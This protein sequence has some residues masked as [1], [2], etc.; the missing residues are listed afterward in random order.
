MDDCISKLPDKILSYILTMLSMKDL[1]KTSILSRRWCKLWGLRK[2]LYFDINNV[3]GSEEELIK[4]G[5]LID[6]NSRYVDLKVSRD[7]FVKRVDQFLKNF[8]G[9]KID[10]FLLSFNLNFE[11]SSIIDQ[12]ISF[13]IAKGVEKINLLFLRKPFIPLD[14]RYKFSFD[15]FSKTDASNL[16][17]LHLENCHLCHP[18]NCDFE[19][20]KNLRSLSLLSVKVDEIFIENLLSNCQLLEELSLVD[21]EFKSSTPKIISSSLCHLNVS[22]CCKV[23][24]NN[25][26]TFIELMLVDCLK[27]TSLECSRNDLS[28][29]NTNQTGS[30]NINSHVL[31]RI[32]FC[33][34]EYF[35]AFALCETFPELEVMHLE[36]YPMVMPLLIIA[37]PFKHLTQLD[38]FIYFS[39]TI[40]EEC[41]L[42]LILNFFQAS[43]LLQKLSVMIT[44]PVLFEIDKNIRDIGVFSHNEVKVIELGGCVGNWYEIEFVMNVLK[45]AP[46]LEQIVLSPYWREDDSS[47]WNSNPVWFQSGRV[48]V[49]EKLQDEEIVGREKLVLL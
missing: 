29:L 41:G 16:K 40:N 48:K 15:L 26:T 20:F 7:E 11:Q 14:E 3:L 19:P 37:Q 10:S 38:C 47:D 30:L 27:L 23:S 34:E 36:I 13:A 17:H 46:K 4:H 31:K 5:Y 39:D 45:Y 24:S 33:I 6:A 1:L 32:K 25:V 12:W 35:D 2:D 49:S 18:S 21:C 42:M 22:K 9:T 28:T 43:P 8:P 44:D